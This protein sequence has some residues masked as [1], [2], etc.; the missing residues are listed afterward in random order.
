MSNRNQLS[1]ADGLL[2]ARRITNKQLQQIDAIV[3]WEPLVMAVQVLDKTSKKTGGS[4]EKAL[5][6]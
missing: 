2:S 6:R 5:F 4:P 1:F 3:D